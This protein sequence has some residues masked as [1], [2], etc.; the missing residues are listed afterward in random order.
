MQQQ[1]SMLISIYCDQV[2]ERCYQLRCFVHGV[3]QF[4]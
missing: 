3:L 4:L 2:T 1:N